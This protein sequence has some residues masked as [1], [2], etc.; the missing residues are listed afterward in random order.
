MTFDQFS[1][2]LSQYERGSAEFYYLNLTAC[3]EQIQSASADSGEAAGVRNPHAY[4][5]SL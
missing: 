5:V 1:K 2:A 4:R 3:D